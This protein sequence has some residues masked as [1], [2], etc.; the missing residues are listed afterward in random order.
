VPVLATSAA[1][2]STPGATPAPVDDRSRAE[3]LAEEL[4]QLDVKFEDGA[5]SDEAAYRR[6][7][8]SL[9]RRL[10]ETVEQDPTAL[11]PGDAGAPA[12]H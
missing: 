1:S 4:A 12:S 7:R 6:V 3:V 8:E 10:V 2:A 5:F 9:V 11:S